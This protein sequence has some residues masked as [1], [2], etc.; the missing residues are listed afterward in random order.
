MEWNRASEYEAISNLNI[1]QL[2]GVVDSIDVELEN[3][4]IIAQRLVTIWTNSSP[5][6]APALA[7]GSSWFKD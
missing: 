4:A 1:A 3:D 7:L 6:Q 2:F 5:V